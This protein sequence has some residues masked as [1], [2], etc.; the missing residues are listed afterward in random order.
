[1][2]CWGADGLGGGAR[3]GRPRR[4]EVREVCGPI[5]K[6][7]RGWPSNP[8]QRQT[9]DLTAARG[10]RPGVGKGGGGISATKEQLI[11]IHQ[12]LIYLSK[13]ARA[14]AASVSL[15]SLGT[16]SINFRDAQ[17]FCVFLRPRVCPCVRTA[18]FIVQA[19]YGVLFSREKD[20]EGRQ[21]VRHF[22]AGK[23]RQTAFRRSWCR[24]HASR[25]SEKKTFGLVLY[26]KCSQ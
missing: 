13:R 24:R 20:A 19:G 2:C 8:K 6:K 3:R 1:M 14:L 17:L 26:L 21:E 10:R 18:L 16:N 4:E 25:K 5:R 12:R 23:R 7:H 22:T 15:G 11:M 9:R